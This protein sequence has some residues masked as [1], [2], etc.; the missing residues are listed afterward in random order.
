MAL[1][2][3]SDT[4]SIDPRVRPAR[5]EDARTVIGIRDEAIRTSTALWIDTVPPPE[6]A[7]AWFEHQRERGTVLVAEHDGEVVGFAAYG[8]LRPYDGYRHTAEDSVYL[9]EAAQGL[10]LGR[11]LLE[12]LVV[13]A[14]E[15]GEHSLIGMIEASN[16]A[17]LALHARCGFTEVGRIPQAGLKFGRW[18]DL[19]IVQRLLVEGDGDSASR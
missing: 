9:V 1:A 12:A 16:A 11:A 17:S 4:P 5:P 19:V 14:T 13:R 6:D 7:S 15:T 10:G 8:P 18:L 3:S 2:P